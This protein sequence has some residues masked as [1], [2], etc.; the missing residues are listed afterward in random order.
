MLS[1]AFRIA[2]LALVGATI[3]AILASLNF[4]RWP[5]EE[6]PSAPEIVAE[7]PQVSLRTGASMPRS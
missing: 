5:S 6:T 4:L 3:A 7:A 1:P 2:A